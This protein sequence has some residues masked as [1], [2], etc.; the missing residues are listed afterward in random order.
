MNANKKWVLTECPKPLIEAMAF[1]TLLLNLG[2]SLKNEVFLSVSNKDIV[3]VLQA[4]GKEAN[5]RVGAAEFDNQTMVEY[6]KRLIKHWNTGGSLSY[7]E[8]D[9]IYL[10]SKSIRLLPLVLVEL[11]KLGFIIDPTKAEREQK[12]LLAMN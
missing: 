6:W 11:L 1:N 10:D 4:Q 7:D 9:Q 8:K 3:V 12:R 5:F 2:F